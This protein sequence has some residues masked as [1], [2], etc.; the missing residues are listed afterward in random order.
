MNA[1]ADQGV[2]GVEVSTPRRDS[3][4]NCTPKIWR[5]PSQQQQQTNPRVRAWAGV[6]VE[7]STLPPLSPSGSCAN[8]FPTPAKENPR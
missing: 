8:T 7:T 2:E 6:G 3:R 1:R 4:R 5:I